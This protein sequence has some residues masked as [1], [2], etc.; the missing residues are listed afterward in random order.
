MRNLWYES[1]MHR[2]I[3]DKR[4]DRK[5]RIG[6]DIDRYGKDVLASD[7]LKQAFEQTH[8]T[9]STVG[10]HTLRVAASSVMI[11]YALRKLNIKVNIPAVI[12]GAL[13]HDLGILGRDTKFE[14]NK[15]CSREHPG[16]SVKVA[17]ELIPDLTEHSADIIERHMWPAGQSKAPNSIEGVI[18]SAADKYSAVKDIV[19]G[20]DVKHTGVKNV[21]HDQAEKLKEQS[22]TQTEKVREFS[23]ELQDKVRE[24]IRK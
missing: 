1:T 8:H 21:A 2:Q 14:N 7:E 4:S 13:C 5:R 20:S 11:S 18:V 10:E 6:K 24:Q 16:E 12:I 15:E 9:W 3:R 23:R 19:K 17:R 22:R